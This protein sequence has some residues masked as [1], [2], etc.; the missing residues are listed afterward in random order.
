MSTENKEKYSAISQLIEV[1]MSDGHLHEEEIKFIHAVG[2][3]MGLGDDELLKLIKSPAPFEPFESELDRIV[4]FQRICLLMH[5]DGN[6]ESK[7]INT[8]KSLG[9]K[10]G[11]NPKATGEVL[12]RMN[13]YENNVIPPQ[14]LINIYL[15]YKN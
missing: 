7:E 12:R 4:Q 5:V 9:L 13:E 3:Q 14:D 8:V 15:K 10:L 11:L 1:A 6:S 2:K